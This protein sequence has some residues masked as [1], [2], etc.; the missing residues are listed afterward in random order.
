M[1]IFY[2]SKS[3]SDLDSEWI[4]ESE[5]NKLYLFHPSHTVF[6]SKKDELIELG[7][8]TLSLNML[9]YYL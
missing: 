1:K 7:W 4:L 8:K 9:V 6:E 5:H 2:L 3:L